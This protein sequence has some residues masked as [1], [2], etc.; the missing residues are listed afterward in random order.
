LNKEALIEAIQAA[1][2]GDRLTCEA[3]HQLSERLGVSLEEIGEI[4]NELKIK[5]KACQLGCF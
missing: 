2:P 4:C 1:A 5:I 3:A